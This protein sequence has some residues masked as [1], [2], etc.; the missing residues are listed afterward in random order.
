[1]EVRTLR[2][3]TSASGGVAQAV[4]SVEVHER[5]AP[6]LRVPGSD[7]DRALSVDRNQRP[8]GDRPERVGAV[9]GAGRSEGCLPV[10]R[11]GHPEYRNEAVGCDRHSERG[12]IMRRQ[13][14]VWLSA[15]VL[16]LG[17]AAC[18]S[19]PTSSLRNGA[20]RI[21]LS[22]YTVTVRAGDS[23][24]VRAYLLDDQ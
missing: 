14:L 16:A 24:T 1:S 9:A 18:F 12:M 19:D 4:R 20:T 21:Q 2:R 3:D 23:A 11:Y 8:A 17:A 7:R 6:V 15:A 5:S 10:P 13:G 22:Q